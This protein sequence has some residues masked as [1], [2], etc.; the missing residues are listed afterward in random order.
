MATQ[1]PAY[2]GDD[3]RFVRAARHSRRVRWLRRAVPAVVILSL[4]LIIGA[5]VFNPFRFLKKLPIDLSKL[6]VS[7][8]KITMDAPHLAGYL[9]DR[10]PYEV[11]AKAATQDVT[12]PTKVD[13]LD[14]RAQV[15][16]Q[17]KST[18]RVDAQNGHFDTK[19]QLLDL[20]NQILLQTTTGYQAQLTQA[21]VDLATGI[22]SSDQPVAV[23]LTNGT[24]NSQ[25][26]RITDH[27][28]SAVF[29]GGVTMLLDPPA[30]KTNA[31]ATAGSA[32]AD[33]P[34]ESR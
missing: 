21:R 17:D 27:G 14:I 6:S 29:G 3:P 22:I 26:L 8:T 11:W 16:M 33:A 10:R 30:D 34:A 13:M 4:A 32:P 19:T 2:Q 9:P 24:L 5:S 20:T 12:D 18:L 7:G 23:K 25:N 28:A 31:D 15:Q 1:T